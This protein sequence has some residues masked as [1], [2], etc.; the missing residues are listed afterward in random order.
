MLIE[1][2]M[3]HQRM[4]VRS[5]GYYVRRYK[6]GPSFSFSTRGDMVRRRPSDVDTFDAG[7]FEWGKIVRAYKMTLGCRWAVRRR[8]NQERRNWR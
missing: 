3:R 8:L 1:A 7:I 5:P 2:V 4:R 6:Q